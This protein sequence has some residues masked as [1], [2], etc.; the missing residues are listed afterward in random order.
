MV[1]TG[2]NSPAVYSIMM[3][4]FSAFLK[5][6]NE[7]FPDRA[8]TL[9]NLRYVLG[10]GLFVAMFLYLLKPF[11]FSRNTENL[12]LICL[13]FGCVT[14][15]CMISFDWFFRCVLK[16]KTDV[17]SWTLWKWVVQV[18]LLVLWISVGNFV[19]SVVIYNL[20][21]SNLREL[22]DAIRVTFLVGIFP[23]IFSGLIVQSQAARIHEQQAQNMNPN[24][25]TDKTV[26]DNDLLEI[27]VSEKESLQLKAS[28]LLYVE[29]MQNY[30]S[31]RYW[32]KGKLSSKLIRNTITHTQAKLK[33]PSIIR[34][35][36]SFLVNV[37]AVEE[38]SGN[39]Q[40]LK[41]KLK[42]VTDAHVPVS[43]TYIPEVKE[44]LN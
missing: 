7:P 21:F 20:E 12:L 16:I 17:T 2:F 43:R 23:V 4:M 36:R 6:L 41:L 40:G 22:L 5:Q 14:I 24:A 18:L 3:T 19:F 15:V 27:T 1:R 34:C 35:H 30:I 10:V 26:V 11:G 44:R 39:A 33:F 28:D 25:A 8:G 37:D 13:G 42:G 31:I 29:A 9:R 32:D 38:V